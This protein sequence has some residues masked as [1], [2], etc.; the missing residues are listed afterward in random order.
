M[1]ALEIQHMEF[2]GIHVEAAF[3]VADQRAVVDRV[4]EAENDLDEFP[5]AVVA[6]GM[7]QMRALAEIMRL[8]DIRRR[9]DIPAGP[10]LCNVVERG[11]HARDIV[12]LVIGRGR[13]R[14]E[15]ELC[16]HH[17]ERRQ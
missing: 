17:G 12:W 7:R 9:D 11:E 2:L 14:R 16:R 1:L 15:A 3:L 6:L 8:A 5:G 4:P 13:T 10:A